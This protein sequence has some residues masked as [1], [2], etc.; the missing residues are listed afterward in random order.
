M[1]RRKK[2]LFGIRAY[3]AC[4]LILPFALASA[5]A[6]AQAP[7]DGLALKEALGFCSQLDSQSD[8]LACFDQLATVVTVDATTATTAAAPAQTKAAEG[9]VAPTRKD[10]PKTVAASED[11]RYVIL[12]ADDP[13][14]QQI[15]RG[16]FLSG[17]F[18]REEYQTKIVATK[19]NNMSILFIEMENGEIWRETAAYLRKDPKIGET[20][21]L[22]PRPTGGWFAVF[23]DSNKRTRMRRFDIDS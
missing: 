15:E 12:R 7:E 9:P 5:A 14:L 21:I 8:R 6:A 10:A 22:R 19:R 18:Q 13:K 1:I 20:V 16:G 17:F 3:A 23:P 11:Q 4:G 2:D